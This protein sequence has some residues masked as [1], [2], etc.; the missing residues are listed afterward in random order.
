MDAQDSVLDTATNVAFSVV[1]AILTNVP[2]GSQHHHGSSAR[3]AELEALM[4]PRGKLSSSS[5]LFTFADERMNIL[6]LSFMVEG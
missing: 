6:Y 1:Q 2:M 5:E 3:V 4:G